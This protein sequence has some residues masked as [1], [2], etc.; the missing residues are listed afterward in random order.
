MQRAMD[1]QILSSLDFDGEEDGEST[2]G[3]WDAK[4]VWFVLLVLGLTSTLGGKGR[5]MR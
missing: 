5:G 4:V 2:I 3:G 1:R